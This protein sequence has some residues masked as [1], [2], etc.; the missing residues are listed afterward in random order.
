RHSKS[1][2]LPLVRSLSHRRARSP[3]RSL[4]PAGSRLEPDPRHGARADHQAR[5]R[6]AGALAARTRRALHRH[7]KLFRV[8]GFGLSPAEGARPDRQP[9][10]HRDEGGRQVQGQDHGAHQLWQTDFTYLKVIGWGWFYLSTVLDDFSRYI[11]AWKLC[12]TMK[13][14]DITAT[15]DLALKA[16]GLDQ[17]K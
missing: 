14:E 13:A 9:G 15:L 7:G 16:S 6:R 1:D 12:P 17:A 10:L 2:L 5:A 8:R 3:G 4:V 11:I